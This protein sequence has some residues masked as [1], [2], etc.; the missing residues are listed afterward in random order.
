MG[1]VENGCFRLRIPKGAAKPYDG[2]KT[3]FLAP[4]R[5]APPEAKKFF[6]T[7]AFLT[8]FHGF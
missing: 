3:T 4:R 2:V 6:E 7:V 5:A 8:I 1:F